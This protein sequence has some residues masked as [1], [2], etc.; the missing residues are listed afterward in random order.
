VIK[1]TMDR[2]GR[3]AVPDQSGARLIDPV[4]FRAVTRQ[5]PC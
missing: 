4:R 1:L 3:M 2:D 5:L